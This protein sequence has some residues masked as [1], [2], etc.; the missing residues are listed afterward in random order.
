MELVYEGVAK[1]GVQAVVEVLTDSKTRAAQQVRL[2]FKEAG[3]ELQPPGALDYNFKHVGVVDVR[4][5]RARHEEAL[6]E[7]ALGAGCEDVEWPDEGTLA[8]EGAAEAVVDHHLHH[9]LASHAVEPEEG[10]GHA[11][12]V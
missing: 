10:D 2:V 11:E 6:L 1:H 4:C 8:A 12:S 5:D 3:G 7:L 9:E